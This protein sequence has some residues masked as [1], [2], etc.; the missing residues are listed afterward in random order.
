MRHHY[1]HQSTK[2]RSRSMPALWR[3][4]IVTAVA[5]VVITTGTIAVL[6][7]ITFV[8]KWGSTGTGPGQFIAPTG[9]AVDSSGNVYVADGNGNRFEKFDNNGTF[10]LQ[11][12]GLG[13]IPGGF[14]SPSGITVDSTGNIYVTDNS[15][16]RTSKFN[17]SGTYL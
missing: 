12:G 4:S 17:S 11:A 2:L 14:V 10:L 15:T 16:F 7:S 3:W 5:L 8:L 13:D 6:A 9:V 1:P